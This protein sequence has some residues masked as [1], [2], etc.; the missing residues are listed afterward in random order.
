[1]TTN[2]RINN[3][4]KGTKI[5]L[6]YFKELR[7]IGDLFK[8][9]NDNKLNSIFCWMRFIQENE[10]VGWR[11]K[12]GTIKMCRMLL[13]ASSK[14]PVTFYALFCP[15]YKKG[16]R[17]YGFRTDGIGVT[18]ML[19]IKNLDLANKT[20]QKLGFCVT[21]AVAIFFNLAIEQYD[22]IK[23]ANE[24]G[25]LDINAANLKLK[26]PKNFD[27]VKLSDIKKLEKTIGY[28]GLLKNY[29]KDDVVIKRIVERGKKFYQLFNWNQESIEKRSI[30][31]ANSESFVATYLKE[32]Y[33]R[34]I[35]IYTPTMLERSRIYAL[36]N[37]PD[38]I[39]ILFP[40]K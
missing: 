1:M 24:L 27:F 38:P 34:G 22:K 29:F 35:M 30:V 32:T 7:L 13:E 26:L 2:N 17:V 8:N 25:D 20:A 36:D 14:N 16:P 12:T 6:E 11:S 39:P 3:F 21:R 18:S 23:L 37:D 31:V 4:L 19:G 28:Q 33:P 40:I 5:K 15:S 10:I 9:L